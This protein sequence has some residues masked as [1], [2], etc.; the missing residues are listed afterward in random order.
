MIP[1]R[2]K[3][4]ILILIASCLLILLGTGGGYTMYLTHTIKTDAEIINKLGI[5]RGSIQRLVKIE[6]AGMN[7]EELMNNID[8]YIAEFKEDKIKV[9]DKKDEIQGALDELGQ[10]WTQLKDLIYV[11]REDPTGTNQKLLLTMS[12]NAWDQANSMVLVSQLTSERKIAQ[13]KTSFM[14]LGM[15]LALGLLIIFLMKRY[16]KDT[17]EHLVNYDGLT[18]IYNRRYFNE[19]LGSEI[20]RSER[21]NKDLSLVM[22]DID[23]FKK[24]NDLYGHDVGDS[25]LKEL[26]HLIQLSIRKSDI[27][28]RL[29]GEEFAVITP[30]TNVENALILSE[31]LRKAVEE[32][33]FKHVNNI[34]VSLGVTQ[35][36]SGDTPDT[37]YKRT[38]KALYK[39]KNNGR[40]RSEIEMPDADLESI[41]AP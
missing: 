17:L 8:G 26:A 24:V 31:K 2:K 15:N 18:K 1:I 14:F 13:Y 12:E 11:Y 41:I 27:F 21:Y 37:I 22:I 34:T 3:S 4:T 39:S 23:H 33:Q 16:V 5:I 6:M 35:F 38:D 40:N 36:A 9:Y 25:V 28:A 32:Y 30:E 29:G 19:Q 10:S 7:D 20:I